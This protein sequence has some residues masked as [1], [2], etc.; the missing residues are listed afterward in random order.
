[1]FGGHSL[2]CDG[3]LVALIG[4]GELFVKPTPGGRALARDVAEASPYPGA[5]P[6][7]IIAEQIDNA[8]WLAELIATTA[9]E[10]SDPTPK[11]L[12]M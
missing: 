9:R 8:V 11:K 10:L 4:D 1:M 6:C 2:Y 7:L 12:K 3:R 5:K